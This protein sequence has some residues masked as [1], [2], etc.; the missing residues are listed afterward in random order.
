MSADA[1]SLEESVC[2]LCVYGGGG[3][4]L[5]GDDQDGE[6]RGLTLC[7]HPCL[8]PAPGA[9]C[10]NPDPCIFCQMRAT[11]TDDSHKQQ[12]SPPTPLQQA[13][14][15][16]GHQGDRVEAADLDQHH[17]GLS[18]GHKA[19]FCSEHQSLLHLFLSLTLGF[20]I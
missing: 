10:T 15:Q 4:W 14:P 6:E 11:F 16:V 9:F 19:L 13:S 12:Q 17:L 18:R 2:V 7:H 8:R 5:E 1:G 20:W 3:G